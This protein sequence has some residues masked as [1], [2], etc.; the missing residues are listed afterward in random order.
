MNSQRYVAVC[1]ILVG[2]ASYGLLSTLI[3]LAYQQGFG[4]SQIT[5]AQITI[6]TVMLWMIVLFHKK[7]WQNPFKGPWIRLGI[8]G[9]FGLA[10]STIFFNITLTKLDVSLA[11]VLLFQF[12]WI[13]MLMN[14]ISQ[15][16]RPTKLELLSVTLI[17]FGTLCAVN[18]FTLNIEKFS[19]V[20]LFLGLSSGLSYGWFLFMMDKVKT[21]LTSVMKSAVMLTCSLPIIY[22]IYNPSH[23]TT[24]FSFSIIYWGILLAILG[25]VI[26][27]ISF[28]IAIPK[29]GSSLSAILGSVELPVAVISAI[30]ILNEQVVWIQWIGILII[31]IGIFVSERKL[32][33]A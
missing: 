5:P 28:N 30:F 31:L 1:L 26:P 4:A 23:L 3:K 18:I 11:I 13:T 2:A 10:L 21:D 7:S 33:I 24:D 6:G 16:R 9:I 22:I 27:I 15:K 19:W 32:I 14:A 8:V 12:T 29:L 20:G 17:M 25:Q